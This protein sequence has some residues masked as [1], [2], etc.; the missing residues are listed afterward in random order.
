[1]ESGSEGVPSSVDGYVV[2]TYNKGG[3][4][5]VVVCSTRVGAVARQRGV[6]CRV[7]ANYLRGF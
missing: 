3:G 6:N 1:M 7:A 2:D 4:K 5:W